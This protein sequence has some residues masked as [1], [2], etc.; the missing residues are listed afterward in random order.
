MTKPPSDDELFIIIGDQLLS[1]NDLGPAADMRIDKALQSI[2]DQGLIGE[3]FKGL[4]WHDVIKSSGLKLE[5][6]PEE[7]ETLL[8]KLYQEYHEQFKRCREL[9]IAGQLTQADKDETMRLRRKWQS[10]EKLSRP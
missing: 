9:N 4:D 3:Q 1:I 6:I 5:R 2:L 7:E 10:A 8:H